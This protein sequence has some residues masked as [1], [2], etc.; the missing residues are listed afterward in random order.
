MKN[1][2]K[3]IKTFI[4]ESNKIDPQYD[5]SGLILIPGEKPGDPLFD[6]TLNVINLYEE[7]KNQQPHN[8][9]LNI[10]RELTREIDFFED[11]GKSGKFRNY[12][13][14]IAGEKTTPHMLIEKE[15]EKKVYPLVSYVLKNSSK[16]TPEEAEQLAWKIHNEFEIIHPFID[17][18]GR[19]GRLLFNF[20]LYCCSCPIKI[21]YFNE[22]FK[23]Y[24]TIQN[25][26]KLNYS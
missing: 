9:I 16:I 23:Y 26:R 19:T 25:Y 7:L 11:C 20:I 6:N 4:T 18:N 24:D 13:I 12:P 22:R 17:G 3:S 2:K 5:Y 21:F 15:L 10:H 14:Y 1:S 8:I